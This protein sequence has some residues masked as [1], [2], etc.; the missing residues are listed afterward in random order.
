KSKE[1]PVT[2]EEITLVKKWI[3][4]GARYSEHWSFTKLSRPGVPKV[5]NPPVAVRNVVD[6]FILYKLQQEGVKPSPEADR[7]TLI[8]R[9]YFDLT[10]LP[11]SAEDVRACVEDKTT[12]DYEK[13]LEKLL[14]SPH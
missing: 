9:L 5:E 1:P 8:R 10:G 12:D 14:A 4:E 2:P 6:A 3:S 13:L 7:V 11:P